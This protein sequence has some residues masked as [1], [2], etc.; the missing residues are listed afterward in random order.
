MID[1]FQV[2]AHAHADVGI[3]E[4]LGDTGAVSLVGDLLAEWWQVILAVGVLDVSQ[5]ISSSAHEVVTSAQEVSGGSHLWWVDIGLGY[6]AGLE[7]CGDLAGV[8]PV[9]FGLPAVYGSHV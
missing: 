7:E 9:V 8:D 6:Q 4:L 5:E 2:C 1:E 3:R